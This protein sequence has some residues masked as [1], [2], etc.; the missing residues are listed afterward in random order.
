MASA[1]LTIPPNVLDPKEVYWGATSGEFQKP[2]E[3]DYQKVIKATPEYEQAKKNKVASGT[4]EYWILNSAA[5][6]RAVR[7]ILAVAKE[8]SYDLVVRNDSLKGIN[9][10][11]SLEDATDQVIAKLEDTSSRVAIFPGMAVTIAGDQPVLVAGAGTVLV[12]KTD[13][14]LGETITLDLGNG[15]TLSYTHLAARLVKQGDTV[16]LGQVI[17]R[18]AKEGASPTEFT[19]DTEPPEGETK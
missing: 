4:A 10:P 15:N 2:A 7:A 19:L 8:S 14:A 12:S 3:I 16:T 9:P 17:G 1:A 6:D 13:P 11:P 18:S 5:S